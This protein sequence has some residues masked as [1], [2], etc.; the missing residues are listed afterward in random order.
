M[1]DFEMELFSKHDKSA[2]KGESYFE[3]QRFML[4]RLINLLVVFNPQK[5]IRIFQYLFYFSEG[6]VLSKKKSTRLQSIENFYVHKELERC[7]QAL[8]SLG[9]PIAARPL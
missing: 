4:S 3:R 5:R 1:G 7:I 8:Q 6:N 9:I 2:R